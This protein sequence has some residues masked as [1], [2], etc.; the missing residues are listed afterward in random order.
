MLETGEM[1]RREAYWDRLWSDVFENDAGEVQAFVHDNDR[2]AMV[3]P[4]TEAEAE[5]YVEKWHESAWRRRE[6]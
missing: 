4:M 5:V 1:N 6:E 2:S 3:A